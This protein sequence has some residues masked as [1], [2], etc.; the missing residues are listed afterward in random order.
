MQANKDDTGSAQMLQDKVGSQFDKEKSKVQSQ[1]DA[2]KSEAQKAAESVNDVKSN[3]NSWLDQA[4]QAYT[5]GG[6]QTQAYNDSIGK[7]QNALEGQYSGPRAFD[8]SLSADTQNY[9]QNLQNRDAFDRMMGNLYQEKAGGQLT[10]GGRALQNQLDVS[11]E[12]LANTRDALLKQYAGLG[13]YRDQ[14]VADTTNALSEAEKQYRVNQNSLR[15]YLGNTGNELESN[16][17]RQESQARS[18]YQNE[19][20]SQSGRQILGLTGIG[21][22]FINP[23]GM[24]L[25]ASNATWADIANSSPVSVGGGAWDVARDFGR[26]GLLGNLL[27]QAQSSY[28]A[29]RAALNDFY[30]QED[31]KYGNTA[32]AEER[33]WN[34]IQD[35]LRS[36]ADR[37]KQ[38]FSVRG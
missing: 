35:I 7:F 12:N 38:G 23:N 29:N 30:S 8:Y 14:V 34:A 17:G 9:G 19:F 21:D 5:Y 18:A 15:D 32:D 20:N 26:Q 33:K 3:M 4:G 31:T 6:A 28:D 25:N 24:G 37:K 16:I 13:D 22:D 36:T 10:S 11:N 27:A 2:T 1:A